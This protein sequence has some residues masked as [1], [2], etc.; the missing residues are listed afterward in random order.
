MREMDTL[1]QMA[2]IARKMTGA[3]LHYKDLVA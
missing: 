1:D 2:L 3:Q